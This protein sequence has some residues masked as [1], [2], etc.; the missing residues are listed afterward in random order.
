MELNAPP[1]P[2]SFASDYWSPRQAVPWLC[3]DALDPPWMGK[4]RAGI[5]PIVTLGKQLLNMIGKLV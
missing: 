2:R 3:A 1:M 4:V 5:N